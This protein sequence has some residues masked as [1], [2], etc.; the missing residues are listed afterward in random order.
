M[1]YLRQLMIVLSAYLLGELIRISLHIPLPGNVLGMI[2][3]FAALC[4]GVIK[5]EMIEEV[6]EFLLSH[7]SFFFLPAGV[8]L[9][10]SFKTIKG[11]VLSL[12]IICII[13]TSLVMITS[14]YTVRLLKRSRKDER[15]D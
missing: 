7:L 2:I 8:A 12:L 6:G 11:N 10:T 9:I 14:G 4:S 15:F 5:V 1:K 13:S 3:L